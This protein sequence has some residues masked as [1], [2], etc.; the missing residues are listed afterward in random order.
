VRLTVLGGGGGIPEPGGACSGYLVEHE[1]FHLLLDPGYATYPRLIE[2]V[3]ADDLGAVLV[4]HGHPDHCADLN[5]L[6]RARVFGDRP[7]D[8]LPVCALP[9]ALD[10]ILAIEPGGWLKPVTDL[11]TF[12]AGERFEVGPFEVATFGLPHY[13]PNAGFRLS[14]GGRTVAYTG[15]TGPTDDLLTL[16][17]D[18]DLFLGEATH[19]RRE[20]KGLLHLNAHAVGEYATRA[21]VRHLVLTHLWPGTPPEDALEAARETYGGRLDVA[22]PG[23]VLEIS[24]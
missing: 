3:S 13:V 22:R 21:G 1:G 16:A 4:S 10:A 14:A 15:D 24:R 19:P 23:L 9:G 7:K 6:L 18:A 17:R 20:E 8:T 12:E 2:H 5:P 11:R